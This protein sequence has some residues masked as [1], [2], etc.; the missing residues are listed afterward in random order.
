V[1]IADDQQLILYSHAPRCLYR[2][3]KRD[4]KRQSTL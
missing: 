3:P 4:F 2:L 1:L